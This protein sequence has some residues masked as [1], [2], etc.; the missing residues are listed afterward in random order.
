MHVVPLRDERGHELV[1]AEVHHL[2][3]Q[4][5]LP[6][7]AKRLEAIGQHLVRDA[8]RLP[9][10]LGVPDGDLRHLPQARGQVLLEKVD[11]HRRE[12]RHHAIQLRRAP[13]QE[14]HLQLALR[15]RE[16]LERRFLHVLRRIV[17]P[18]ELR[19]DAVLV[20]RQDVVDALL[21]VPDR[22]VLVALRLLV[23]LAL[24]EELRDAAADGLQVLRDEIAALAVGADAAEQ[25]RERRDVAR[26]HRIRRLAGRAVHRQRRLHLPE[27]RDDLR[28]DGVE[29]RARLEVALVVDDASLNLL[30]QEPEGAERERVLVDLTQT[31]G[32]LRA[33]AGRRASPGGWG[34]RPSRWGLRRRGI[35]HGGTLSVSRARER[36][37]GF[38]PSSRSDLERGDPA[39]ARNSRLFCKP[40]RPGPL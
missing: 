19:A 31:F 12:D 38:V 14:C 35:A 37:G 16:E 4:E 21:G 28:G 18:L 17:E 26:L 9:R 5:P 36:A 24:E 8:V 30:V 29:L 22:L 25:L 33:A 2:L 34:R 39:F 27:L 23:E 13:R 11:E 7:H 6:L 32:A 20:A 3:H 10:G 15:L 1:A 40:R